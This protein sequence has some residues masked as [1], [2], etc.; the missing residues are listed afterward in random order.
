V[1]AAGGT[2]ILAVDRDRTLIELTAAAEHSG[3]EVIILPNDPGGHGA[4]D[5]LTMALRGAD[6]RASVIPT[7]AQVQGLAA[8]AV[9]EPTSDFESAVA[10]MNDAAGHV[11]HGAVTV[12]GSAASAAAGRC[13][14]GDVVGTVLGDL[15]EIGRTVPEVAWAVVERLLS[16]GGELL[17]IVVGE[18]VDEQVPERLADQVRAARPGVD[19]EV[20]HGGQPG[21]ALL[22]GLE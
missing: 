18:D 12:A 7:V 10:A 5:Q 2:P 22:L 19:V 3:G 15:V 21:D 9:H 8:L 14:P 11:R 13:Q 17:T 1:A 20:I 16:G 4:A 6:R